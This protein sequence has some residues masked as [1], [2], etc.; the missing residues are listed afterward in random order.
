MAKS[1]TNNNNDHPLL[2]ARRSQSKYFHGFSS[3]Q[4][5]QLAAICEGFI[6]PLPPPSN[7][8]NESLASFYSDTG[9][10]SPLPHEV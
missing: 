7:N 6:P 9:S 2:R 10:R 3:S 4:I 5:R 1:G 8:C